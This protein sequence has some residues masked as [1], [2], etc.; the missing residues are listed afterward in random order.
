M[1]PV[2]L[3]T[4]Y[5]LRHHDCVVLPGWGAFIA[6]RLPARFDAER[7]DVLLPPVRRLAFNPELTDTDG[8]LAASVGRRDAVTYQEADRIV[9]AGV[10]SAMEQ[11]D[12]EGEFMFGHLGAF[13]KLPGRQACFYPASA[14]VNS[15]YYGLS[16]LKL[17]ALSKARHEWANLSLP[18][19]P[20]V[21]EDAC[22][23]CTRCDDAPGRPRRWLRNA[24]AA[25]ALLALALTVGL[26]LM[27]PIRMEKE[28]DRASIAPVVTTVPVAAGQPAVDSVAVDALEQEQ[29]VAD[30]HE[31][32]SVQP[33]VKTVA[34][35]KEPEG[36][37]SPRPVS[38]FDIDD[39]YIV[40]VASFP[41]PAQASQYLSEHPTMK[42]DVAECDGKYRV[43]S[44]TGR[45]YDEARSQ[46]A[47]APVADAWVCRR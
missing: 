10:R 26:F 41:T 46:R 20:V 47:V 4:E 40:V 21:A 23:A 30:I 17:T 44:A 28:P 11:L 8:L 36:K 39:R 31:Q 29:S 7:P 27:N 33:N 15:R 9:T 24:G 34:G 38:R 35:V 43:Y 45:T 37:K 14:T 16:P 2:V 18:P 19:V 42:L 22:E 25:V 13:M 5:L 1:N 6:Q 3:H 12:T 32:P